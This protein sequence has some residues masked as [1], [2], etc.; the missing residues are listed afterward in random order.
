M[1]KNEENHGVIHI[2]KV[3]MHLIF[4]FFIQWWFSF[5]IFIMTFF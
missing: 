3:S 1:T 5:F 2:V 4:K